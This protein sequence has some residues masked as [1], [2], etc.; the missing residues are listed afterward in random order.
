MQEYYLLVLAR[1]ASLTMPSNW[2]VLIQDEGLKGHPI[3][4]DTADTIQVN[5]GIGRIWTIFARLIA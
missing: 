3:S 2:V 5:M 1:R 4:D